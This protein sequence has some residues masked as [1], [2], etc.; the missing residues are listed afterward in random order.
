MGLNSHFSINKG[1][2]FCFQIG[3]IFDT[4][5]VKKAAIP[6]F[7]KDDGFCDFFVKCVMLSAS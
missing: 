2:L 1:L 6:V 4:K 7:P 3:I 5:T